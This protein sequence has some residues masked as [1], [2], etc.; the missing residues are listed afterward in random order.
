MAYEKCPLQADSLYTKCCCLIL[1]SEQANKG[2]RKKKKHTM[3]KLEGD[4]ERKKKGNCVQ[5]LYCTKV[6]C[7]MVT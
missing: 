4:K 1:V 5:P 6:L 3:G 7:L 2:E